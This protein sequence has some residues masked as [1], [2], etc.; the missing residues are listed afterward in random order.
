LR[1]TTFHQSF[2][3]CSTET[4]TQFRRLFRTVKKQKQIYF[5]KHQTSHV[6]HI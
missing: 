1:S 4:R 2:L 3:D 5:K 6:L